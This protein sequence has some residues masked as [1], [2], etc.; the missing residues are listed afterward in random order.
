MSTKKTINNT[1]FSREIVELLKDSSHQDIPKKFMKI[2]NTRGLLVYHG[3]GSGKTRILADLAESFKDKYSPIILTNKSLHDNARNGIKKHLL[4]KGLTIE[5]ADNQIKKDYTFVSL[6]ASNVIKKLSSYDEIMQ[7]KL[8]IILEGNLENKILIID[9]CHFLFNSITKGSKN[10]LKLYD[11]IMNTKNIKLIFLS[12]T[13][14]VNSGFEIVPCFNMLAGFEIFGNE[15]DTFM[16]FFGNPEFQ[17]K[18]KDRLTGMISYY[19]PQDRSAYPE[20]L[21]TTTMNVPMSHYQY[22]MYFNARKKEKDN[23][24]KSFSVGKKSSPMQVPGSSNTSFRIK[25]RQ[26]SNFAEPSDDELRP[27]FRKKSFRTKSRQISNFADA[28]NK[29]DLNKSLHSSLNEENINEFVEKYCPKVGKILEIVKE[30]KDQIGLI[31]SQFLDHGIELVGDILKYKGFENLETVEQLEKIRKEQLVSNRFA[32]I[33]GNVDT[34]IRTKIIDLVSSPENM[35]GE[36]IKILLITV[37]GATG[38]NLKNIRYVIIMEPFWHDILIQQIIGRAVRYESH[39]GLPP[40][41]RNVQPYILLGVHPEGY[42]I[43]EQTTD[44]H[45]MQ[46]I[47]K[48]TEE[49][50]YF[51]EILKESSLDCTK[52]YKNCRICHPTGKDLYS[53]DLIHD[54][55]LI[56]PCIP[57]R[58][59]E[60]S[61]SEV[62]IDDLKFAYTFEHPENL[63]IFELHLFYFDPKVNSFIEIGINHPYYEKIY[64]FIKNKFGL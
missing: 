7:E 17:D 25:T 13:P 31:Y 47:S 8:G 61:V 27:M 53:R 60:I 30:R 56:S 28:E 50:N 22:G 42:E 20:Q 51:L 55:E 45:L 19:E 21:P 62:M 54:L 37:T 33:S 43:E 5:E 44:Q 2:Y 16:D 41:K 35:N 34:E 11:M 46:V 24:I 49:I 9:E 23:I 10:S 4:K 40:E 59:E 57:L 32:I 48:K 64:E 58:E 36:L 26:I 15:F 18:L 63:N 1:N 38:L 14:I 3:I 29:S 12:A 52:N 39:I 6:N